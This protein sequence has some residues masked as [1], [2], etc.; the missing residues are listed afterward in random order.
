MLVRSQD[1]TKITD[2]IEF[3]IQEIPLKE[4]YGI[5]QPGQGRLFAKYST[6]EKAVK[7]LNMMEDAYGRNCA[8]NIFSMDTLVQTIEKMELYGVTK[9]DAI[10]SVTKGLVKT[11]IFHFPT[12]EELKDEE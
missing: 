11:H 10:N 4:E 6:F 7:A 5:Y 1:N 8:T 12:E 3:A 2:R 9:S